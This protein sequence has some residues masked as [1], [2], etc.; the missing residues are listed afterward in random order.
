[1]DIAAAAFWIALAAVLIARSWKMKHVEQM[2][3]ETIRLLIQKE[4]TL[5]PDMVK[6]L[7]NPKPAEWN[8]QTA[9]MLG[10]KKWEPGESRRHMRV[11]GIIF[12]IAGP[13]IGSVFVTIGLTR[14]FGFNTEMSAG[15]SSALISVGI[16]LVIAFLLLGIALTYASGFLPKGPEGPAENK[17]TA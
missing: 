11:W 8:P 7:L 16:S 3:H 9:A 4:G 2:K 10:L 17:R 6:E 14:V 13:G 1:M 12:M 15:D 5:N